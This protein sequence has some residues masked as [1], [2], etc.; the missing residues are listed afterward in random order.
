MVFPQADG[1]EKTAIVPEL[2][3]Q[4]LRDMRDKIA[5]LEV[6]NAAYERGLKIVVDTY[7]NGEPNSGID[8]AMCQYARAWLQEGQAVLGA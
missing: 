1:T 2:A 4:A 8:A 6:A 5:K 3:A 7:E